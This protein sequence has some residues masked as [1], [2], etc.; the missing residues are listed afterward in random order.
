LPTVDYR[1]RGSP[2]TAATTKILR[3]LDER[4]IAITSVRELLG[5]C[6]SFEKLCRTVAEWQE[7]RHAELELLRAAARGNGSDRQKPYLYELLGEHPVL[8]RASVY[9]RFA[10]ESPI[11]QVVNA[12]FGMWVRLRFYNVWYNFATDHKASQSQF[13]HRD[14]EDRYILKVFVCLTTVD[15]DNGPF[16]YA[17]GTHTKGAVR[18]VPAYRHRDGETPRSDDE[19]MSAVVPCSSW[20]KGTG[21]VG[22]MI[23][24]DT[25]GYHKG[26]LARRRDRVMFACEFTSLAAG[27]GGIS[28]K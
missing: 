15:D 13:W 4:G 23:F 14:P 18:R 28:T 20:V 21:P 16:T 10:L 25:R 1:I 8:D 7:S 27:A 9:G 22:T 6:E 2:R 17:P 11:V 19:Q 26:G 5:E 24:A 12:Y 3:E